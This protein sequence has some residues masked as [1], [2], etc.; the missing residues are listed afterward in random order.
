MP[1]YKQF[2]CRHGDHWNVNDRLTTLLPRNLSLSKKIIKYPFRIVRTLILIY[3]TLIPLAVCI[4]TYLQCLYLSWRFGTPTLNQVTGPCV[5]SW[6][7]GTTVWWW[8]FANFLGPIFITMKLGHLSWICGLSRKCIERYWKKILGPIFWAKDMCCWTV[9]LKKFAF[10]QQ[11]V[12][13]FQFK[14]AARCNQHQRPKVSHN[15]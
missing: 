15:Q 3:I 13:L 11:P 5:R 12:L 8:D 1:N 14:F 6:T 4:S 2:S 7:S 9:F 10:G